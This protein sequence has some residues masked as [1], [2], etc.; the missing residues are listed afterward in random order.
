MSEKEKSELLQMAKSLSLKYDMKHISAT[1][2]NPVI[3][4]NKID[5][6]RLITF[7]TEYNKFIN[8]RPKTFKPIIDKETKLEE[9]LAYRKICFP[10]QPPS[11]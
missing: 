7:L 10:I 11:D 8:H 9:G 3:V 6:D 5:M 4:D 2:H 1:R